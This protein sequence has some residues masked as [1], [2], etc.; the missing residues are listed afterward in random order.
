MQL[1]DLFPLLEAP[2]EDFN[3]VGDWT[4]SSSFRDP[5]DRKILTNPR[6][7][8]QIIHKWS[9]TV[10]PFNMYFVNN[11]EANRHTEVGEVS[12]EWLEKNMPKTLPQLKLRDDAVNIIYTNN[13]GS[14]RVPMTSWIMAHR[15]G[16]AIDRYNNSVQYDFTEIRNTVLRT[17]SNILEEYYGIK[18]IP[19]DKDKLPRFS[20]M[21]RHKTHPDTERILIAFY[22]IIGKMRSARSKN[23]RNENEFVHELLAQY[24]I[25]G[26]VTFNPLPEN[27]FYT[28]PR[29][30]IPIRGNGN[31]GDYQYYNSQLETLAEALDEQFETLLETCVGRI[32]VM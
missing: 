21:N 16:H 29:R 5:Q 8:Q 14:E 27:F 18:D 25:T 13:K 15:F 31:P 6:A 32:F 22:Q 9:K 24:I 7:Q 19:Y 26:H 3:L 10:V 11:A 23:L 2:I 1:T 17:V 20:Y 28:V 30:R 4:R 12:T